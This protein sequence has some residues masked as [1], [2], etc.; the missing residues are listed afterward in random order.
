[1]YRMIRPADIKYR[2][3]NLMYHLYSQTVSIIFVVIAAVKHDYGIST[4]DTCL[5]AAG[6]A[7]EVL[8]VIPIF[9]YL[10]GSII[11]MAIADSRA[12]SRR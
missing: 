7:S 5:I 10:P 9:L 2:F 4:L 8:V 11:V 12:S 1:M 6:S 3:R